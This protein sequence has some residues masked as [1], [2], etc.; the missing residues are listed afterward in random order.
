MST[1]G[2]EYLERWALV[3][4][5]VQAD[6]GS[7]GRGGGKTAPHRRRRGEPRA[8]ARGTGQPA[9]SRRRRGRT[10][11][12]DH[13]PASPALTDERLTAGRHRGLGPAGPDLLT[14][15]TLARIEAVPHRYLRTRRHPAAAA[16]G[17]ADD[18][19]DLYESATSFDEVYAAIVEALV[20]RRR[21]TARAVRGARFD[22]R[23]RTSGG[24]AARRPRV[25]VEVL[26]ALSYLDLAWARLGVDPVALG[27]RLVD[28]RRF[29]TEAAGERGPLLVGQC[30]QP[31]VLS[32]I[33]LALDDGPEVV[34]LQRLGLPDES[35]RTWP[36]TS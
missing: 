15:G 34:V 14:A 5:A 7:E 4:G 18:F 16:V 35:V 32:D 27:A 29:A 26:P 28:G 20:T 3:T 2:A 10:P 12:A 24:A 23:G 19:D 1:R 8:T 30:D 33:K 9:G 13:G 31:H 11:P 22:R 25:E 36:G 6:T 17:E 21:T